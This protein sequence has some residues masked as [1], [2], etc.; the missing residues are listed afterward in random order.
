MRRSKIFVLI[1]ILSSI[2][3]CGS[4]VAYMFKKETTEEKVFELGEVSC[5]VIDIKNNTNNTI[6]SITVQNTGN[7]ESY[8]RV[9]VISYWVQNVNGEN[10]RT[11]KASI[12]P[13]ILLKSGWIHDGNGIY[14]YKVS[15]SPQMFTGE[16]LSSPITLIEEDGQKQVVEIFAESI[17]ALPSNA[18]AD[19]WGITIDGNGNI[20]L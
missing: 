10:Q 2:L 7:L 11:P 5:E 13:E 4:V 15:V 14:Y 19:A 20:K 8:I 3:V 9:K 1:A 6:T 12:I 17:Q 18:A 16:M